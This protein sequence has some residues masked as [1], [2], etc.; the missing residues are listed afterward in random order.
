MNVDAVVI[1]S[2]I[3]VAIATIIVVYLGFKIV[4]LMKRD[5]AN[6]R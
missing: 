1:G 3:T 2:A 4:A 6:K 5:E